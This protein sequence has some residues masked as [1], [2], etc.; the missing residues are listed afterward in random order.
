MTLLLFISGDR[1]AQGFSILQQFAAI[2]ELYGLTSLMGGPLAASICTVAYATVPPVIYFSGCGY[3]EPALFMSLAGGLF[4]LFLSFR[5]IGN[6][7]IDG[8]TGLGCI[9]LLGFLG[10]WMSALKYSGLVYLGLFGL[11]V[12]WGQRKVPSKK[13]LR[14]IAAFSLSAAPGLCWMVWNWVDLGNPVYPM[15][16]FLFG[17]KGWDQTRALAMSLYFDTY[18]MGRN[19]K[20]YLMLPWNLAFAGGFD[21]IRFDGAMGPFLIVFLLLAMATTVLLIRRRRVNHMIKEVGLMFVISAAFFVFGTQQ[22]RFWVPSHMLL[23]VFIAPTVGFLVDFVKGK[24]M[25]KV[26]LILIVVA[27]L[28]WNLWFLGEQFLKIGYFKPV[29]GLE[30]ERDFLVRKIPGYPALEFINQN[31][32]KSSRLMCVWTGAYG[33]YIN[34]N[35]YSDTFIEDFTLKEFIHAS[36]DGKELSQKL[37]RAGFTHLSLNVFI[38]ESNMK[39]GEGL[40]LGEILTKESR[41]LFRYQYY[42][43]YEIQQQQKLRP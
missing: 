9:S 26:T 36:V 2:G 5:S 42:G 21:T 6:I 30:Q 33:Y 15:A 38:S 12:L 32:P 3:V 27:S 41:E 24:W 43:V 17:G 34:R 25:L 8:N 37:M 31:L 11:T 18:G 7:R 16:W 1:G 14:V 28:A 10:G 20:D 40:I 4:T 13:G 19:L 35:Y 23:C 22:V 29:L 39:R